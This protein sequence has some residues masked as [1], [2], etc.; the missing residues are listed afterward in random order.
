MFFPALLALFACGP[1]PFDVAM[2]DGSIETLQTFLVENPDHRLAYMAVSAIEKRYGEIAQESNTVEAWDDYMTRYPEGEHVRDGREIRERLMY[3]IAAAEN[4]PESWQAFLDA[5][6]YSTTPLKDRAEKRLVVAPFLEQLQFGEVSVNP[7]NLA[8]N[9]E[10]PMDGYAVTADFH[11]TTGQ[12]IEKLTIQI[13]FTSD[14]DGVIQ[15]E[16]WPLVADRN[17]DRT[18]RTELEQRAIRNNEHREF[19]FTIEPIGVHYNEGEPDT[20]WNR[21]AV[22]TPV[23]IVFAE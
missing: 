18:G 8:E 19:V 4:T 15:S 23:F 10:G 6:Q 1:D 16:R 12:T 2:D 7:A 14:N 9:P 3:D 17:P 20:R 13:D 11:N 5:Y 22:L 21:Q